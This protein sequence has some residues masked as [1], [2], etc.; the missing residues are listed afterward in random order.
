MAFLAA[1]PG[2]SSSDSE[3]AT[4]SRERRRLTLA[5]KV[6]IGELS[7]LVEEQILAL[8]GKVDLVLAGLSLLL[9]PEWLQ[10]VNS[11]QVICGARADSAT[12]SRTATC[13]TVCS[14]TACQLLATCASGSIDGTN[15]IV[16]FSSNDAEMF[17]ISDDSV[18][19]AVQTTGS[20]EPLCTA[21]LVGAIHTDTRSFMQVEEGFEETEQTKSMRLIGFK[22]KDD[23]VK[24]FLISTSTPMDRLVDSYCQLTRRNMNKTWFS[25]DG[26]EELKSLEQLTEGKVVFVHSSSQYSGRGLP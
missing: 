24:M 22:D 2:L 19:V 7:N 11:G 8:D 6:A 26:K 20:W 3:T 5:A 15:T 12:C 23:T 1:P 18:E 10:K 17:N 25:T 9:G 14:S 16:E 4:V 13:D 21:C